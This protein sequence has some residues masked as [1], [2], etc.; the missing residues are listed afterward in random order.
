M[1]L[2]SGNLGRILAI[3]LIASACWLTARADTPLQLLSAGRAD[4]LI[5]Y[6]RAHL[7]GDPSD[8]EGWNLLSRAYLSEELWDDAVSASEKAVALAPNNSEY[9]L[10]LGRAYGE[11]AEHSIFVTAMRLAKKVHSEFERAVQ[12]QSNNLA[13]QSDLAEF[14]IEAPAFLGGGKDKAQQ[15]AA[16][17]APMDA[18]TAHWI[19]ARIAEK[20]KRN[21]D[22]EREYRAAAT[23][24]GDKASYWLDLAGFYRRTGRVPEMEQA[25]DHAV[26]AGGDHGDVRFEAAQL[27]FRAG[28]NYQGAVQLVQ[29][30]ISSPAKA[31][32]APAFQ[33]HYLLGSIYEKLGNRKQAADEYRAALSLASNFGPAQE[34]LHRISQ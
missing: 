9:H 10:W 8:A 6:L 18:A 14:F 11:K 16:R 31:E 29:S 34:A 26:S 23:V 15:Q 32:S 30:Y 19:Q 20:D 25:I 13:A 5:Q 28:R 22:A 27:L 12:L 17:I 7:K 3:L 33:A 21:A 2:R 1:S 4:E 24:S